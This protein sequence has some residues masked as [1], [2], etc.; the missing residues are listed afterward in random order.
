MQTWHCGSPQWYS[1][2]THTQLC[3]GQTSAGQETSQPSQQLAGAPA[4]P[5]SHSRPREQVCQGRAAPGPHPQ[6]APGARES[7]SGSWGPGCA[8]WCPSSMGAQLFCPHG[9][10]VLIPLT[11]LRLL[12]T[13]VAGRGTLPEAVPAGQG[14]RPGT[15]APPLSIPHCLQ[16]PA[17]PRQPG[18]RIYH[19]E[20]P[21][22]SPR[23]QQ[24]DAGGG[25]LQCL[26]PDWHIPSAW[27]Q[28]WGAVNTS[29][30]GLLDGQGLTT[31]S[32][33]PGPPSSTSG[34]QTVSGRLCTRLPCPSLGHWPELGPPLPLRDRPGIQSSGAGK[35]ARRPAGV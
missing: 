35:F 12:P 4:S 24:G 27:S 8:Q 7:L 9:L 23:S 6:A 33:E 10:A 21:L 11:A 22:P 28:G 17:P 30:G 29:W 15:H 26:S 13:T 19:T 16:L 25:S 32:G 31:H 18:H 34:P 3:S 14:S 1:G 20:P 5:G 2:R